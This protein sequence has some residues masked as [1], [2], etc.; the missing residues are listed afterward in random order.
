NSGKKAYN[1]YSENASSVLFFCHPYNL[2]IKR[3]SS[4]DPVNVNAYFD[5]NS[6][7]DFD[8]ADESILVSGSSYAKV[9]QTS[10][11]VPSA[12]EA[13]NGLVRMRL[14]M[15]YDNETTT[16]CGPNTSGETEDYNLFLTRDLS[17]P[18]MV[19]KGKLNNVLKMTH[20]FVDS[21]VEVFD[22][23]EGDISNRVVISSDLDVNVPGIYKIIYR[24]CDCSEN[25]VETERYVNVVQN[26]EIPTLELN[27]DQGICIEARRDNPDYVDPGA[28]AYTFNPPQNLNSMIVIEGKVNTRRVGQYVIKYS[29]SNI[30][31]EIVEKTRNV[32][33]L[34]QTPPSM[35]LPIDTNIQIGQIWLDPVEVTDAYDKNPKVEL[36]WQNNKALNN[37]V[38][39][40]YTVTY[41][42]KDSS[43]NAAE[44]MTVHF[45]VDDFIAPEIQL[46]STTIVE[47]PVRT[48]YEPA[49]ASVHDNFYPRQLISFRMIYSDVN[50]D[51]LGTYKEVYEAIDGSGNRSQASRTV[52]VVDKEAPK[53]WGESIHGC[54]GEN[55]WPFWNLKIS[56]NYYSPEELKPLIEIVNQ[57]VNIW[58]EGIYT[59]LFRITDPSNNQSLD[60]TRYV[61]FRYF[62]NCRNSTVDI[63]DQRINVPVEVTPNP[64]TGC[65]KIRSA[66]S[67][68]QANGE[69]YDAQ[70]KLMGS[71]HFSGYT[72]DLDLS[73]LPAG[74]YQLKIQDNETTYTL[75]LMIVN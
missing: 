49:P 67:L 51:V 45:K 12:A 56:D 11:T 69:L 59:I 71:Y 20:T 17:P 48:F 44:P 46:N 3:N 33:V 22:N 16:V 28:N 58:E 53:I 35:S 68:E 60:F 65:F 30:I 43:G 55:I 24:A 74:V 23:L 57:N 42:A 38:K 73:H 64:G 14:I 27:P 50:P 18:Q 54:V 21:G 19:L 75:R 5:W 61:D 8:D 2:E 1:D 41:T 37:L 9:F 36:H 39:D 40:I 32:C 29:I 4:K 7:G 25:C 66:V 15:N 34:D 31:G 26:I 52:L 47:H 63:M 10:F 72:S 6:D 62:P 13:F 70:G